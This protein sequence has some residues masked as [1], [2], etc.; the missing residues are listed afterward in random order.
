M[1]AAEKRAITAACEKLIARRLKPV[2]LPEIRPEANSIYTVDILFRWH[3]ASCRFLQR[4]R[5]G[6]AENLGEEFDRP[7]ARLDRVAPDRF[8]IMWMR[9]TGRWWPLH[10]DLSLSR[11]MR[12]L[13]TDELLQ[14]L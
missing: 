7:F 2:H 11:A 5:S 13:A 8:D 10:R 6:F 9:H 4:D 3:G 14:P 1:D 12:I